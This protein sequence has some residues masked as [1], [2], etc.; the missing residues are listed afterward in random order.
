MFSH[1]RLSF[2]NL[3]DANSCIVSGCI[4]IMGLLICSWHDMT[5]QGT[6]GTKGLFQP[7][8]SKAIES[9]IIR[10]NKQ[11]TRPRSVTTLQ[12]GYFVLRNSFIYPQSQEVTQSGNLRAAIVYVIA[13]LFRQCQTPQ[14]AQFFFSLKS[15]V[16][17]LYYVK[18]NNIIGQRKTTNT[19]KH[20]YP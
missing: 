3:K 17:Y 7:S 14:N 8:V 12:H 9:S 15:A 5:F 2:R 20:F 16:H 6:P 19:E 1:S 10:K 13:R 18:S 4:K 11:K